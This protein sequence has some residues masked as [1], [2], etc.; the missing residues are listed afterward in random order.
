MKPIGGT[1]YC[2]GGHRVVTGLQ[3]PKWM[4][5][6]AFHDGGVIKVKR[7]PARDARHIRPLAKLNT[8]QAIA[9]RMLW[10]RRTK[11]TKRVRAFLERVANEGA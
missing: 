5:V 8:P 6:A 7:L 11:V 2:F 10:R 9:T 3:G 1:L 4:H